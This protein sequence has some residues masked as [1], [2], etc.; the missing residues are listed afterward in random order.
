MDVN[1]A[2]NKTVIL[3]A[4]AVR[5]NCWVTDSNILFRRVDGVFYRLGKIYYSQ[6]TRMYH[7]VTRNGVRYLGD[8]DFEHALVNLLKGEGLLKK[9]PE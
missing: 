5:Y 7:S 9:N 8:P 1:G 6:K 3:N 2:D 4:V